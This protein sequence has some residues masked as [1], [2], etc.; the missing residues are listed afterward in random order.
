MVYRLGM[1][2]LGMMLG[3]TTMVHAERVTIEPS[4]DNT[5][6]QTTDG[7]F[8]NG[9]GLGIF[10]GR[11]GQNGGGLRRRAVIAFD[12]AAAVPSGA[13][14][15]SAS[16][17]MTC[18]QTN[19]GPRVVTLHRLEAD[20]GEGTSFGFGGFGAASTPGDA[21]WLHTF[22]PDLFWAEPGGDFADDASTQTTVNSIATYTWESTAATVE[23]VQG[24]LDDPAQNYGWIAVGDESTQMTVKRFASREWTVPAER[25]LLTLDYEMP[26]GT[27]GDLDGSGTVGPADLA[28][29]LAAWGQCEE[30]PEDLDGDG[31]VGPADLAILLANWG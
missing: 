1:T 26:K 13:I 30:C 20:W 23:D 14:V 22:Y 28:I 8:S 12:V 31:I 9:A 21:T 27:P 18:V 16:L 3:A 17:T 6:I 4:K 5:L 25:P 2:A 24:W 11:V 29:L 15:T 7:G 10:A 19:A